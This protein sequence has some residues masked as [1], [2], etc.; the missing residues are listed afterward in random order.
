MTLQVKILP[1]QYIHIG[2][3]PYLYQTSRGYDRIICFCYQGFN[4]LEPPLVDIK[5]IKLL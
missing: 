3:R 2:N 1:I 5:L 4:T